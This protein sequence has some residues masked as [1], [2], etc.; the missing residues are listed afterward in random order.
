MWEIRKNNSPVLR[1]KCKTLEEVTRQDRE[2]LKQMAH[3]M[4]KHSGVGLAAP[5]IGITKRMIVV[6]IGKGVHSLINPCV[7]K[8]I[9]T[10]QS[11]DE[12]CLS[13][14]QIT[15]RV[16]RCTK[17]V[18]KAVDIS[19]ESVKIK[20]QG[21]LARVLQHEIDHLDGKLIIDYLPWYRRVFLKFCKV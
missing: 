14:P 20:A 13:L 1:Q 5:Q 6:D 7:V 11:M 21:L 15:V 16:K 19:G 18:V 9:G 17:I 2:L 8:K 4:R 10:R 3:Q 12:G